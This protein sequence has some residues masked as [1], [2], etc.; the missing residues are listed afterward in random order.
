[1]PAAIAFRLKQDTIALDTTAHKA[2]AITI[3][4]GA[5]I[6]AVHP[7]IGNRIDVIWEGRTVSMFAEDVRDRGE[8]VENLK[9]TRHA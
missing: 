4:K 6:Q 7:L 9:R 2:L 3:P 5:I 1:M 8:T